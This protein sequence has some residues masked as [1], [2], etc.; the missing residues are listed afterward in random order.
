NR[1][2]NLEVVHAA[3]RATT[4]GALFR[5]LGAQGSVLPWAVDAPNGDVVLE[6]PAETVDDLLESRGWPEVALVK[7]D[8]E[9]S[10]L[11]ALRGMAKL[12][13]RE[14]APVL[15]IECNPVALERQG[16]SYRAVLDELDARGYR[17][18]VIDD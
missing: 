10:E 3:A 11:A 6:V 7:L 5:A 13:G 4:G 2:E 12:L 9:G 17:A 1:F 15:V 8:I 18:L 16:A 14:S